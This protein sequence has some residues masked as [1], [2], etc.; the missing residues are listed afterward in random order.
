[1]D[2]RRVLAGGL[3]VAAVGLI[4]VGVVALALDGAFSTG[5][6]ANS[7]TSHL[8][9]TARST[10]SG[11]AR[12]SNTPY[13]TPSNRP[14]STPFKSPG[15]TASPAGSGFVMVGNQLQY[16][17]SDGTVEPVP[18]VAGLR[19]VLA[20]GVA[21]Y[22][23]LA[24]N[25]Y[26]I[27]SGQVVGQ[28]V[29]AVSMARADGSSAQTGGVVLNGT[30]IS[31]LI[32]TV[33]AKADSA[34][35]RW[36]IALPV[37]IRTATKQVSVQ[38]DE[39]G[40]DGWQDTPR[41]MVQFSGQLP[42]TNAIPSNTGYHV[43]VEELGVSRWQVIDPLRLTLSQS[44]LDTNYLMNELLIYGTGA[45]SASRDILVNRAVPVGR[46][47]LLAS[48]EVSVSLVV[49]GSRMDVGPSQVLSAAG[50]PVFVAAG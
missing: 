36:I 45:P 49:R 42:V 18:A 27:R 37:D 29:P 33:L 32:A 17:A 8:A 26:G 39:F 14:S 12:P 48:D 15:P 13:P 34:S 35:K 22:R 50:V 10:A 24:G 47:M 44:K 5:S 2:L 1:M 11:D 9:P 28:F 21:Q 43:L 20:G 6:P 4:T 38:F 3:T 25:P 31:G 41:V 16:V 46:T 19:V 30:V 23:T 7:G 40:L